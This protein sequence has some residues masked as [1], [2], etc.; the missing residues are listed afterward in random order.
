MAYRLISAGLGLLLLAT[1]GSA[2]ATVFFDQNVTNEVIFGSGNANGSFT[3]DR[4]NGIEL[5]LR[6]K[7]RF[8]ETNQP[9]NTFNSNGDGTY[10]FPAGTPPTGFGFDP[11]SPTTP[12]WNFEWSINSD[13]D[14]SGG[15]LTSF[16]YTL[17]IDFDPGP[18]TNFLAL[19]PI[20]TSLADHAIGDNSTANGAGVEATDAASYAALIA[21]NNLAQNSWNMEFFNDAP[22]DIFDPTVPGIYTIVLTAFDVQGLVLASVSIDVIVTAVPEPSTLALM[23]LGLVGLGG[24][25]WR[26]RASA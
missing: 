23:L 13:T 6:A 14:G 18:G 19:D 4:Q 26:R 7:L 8:D 20:N 22:F 25:A 11:N 9:Q 15:V 1:A 17:Q 10:T 21:S 24:L 16:L 5:G 2:N 12:V 3:V